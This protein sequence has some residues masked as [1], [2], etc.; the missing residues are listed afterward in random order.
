MLKTRGFGIQQII[1]LRLTDEGSIPETCSNA[2]INQ[3]QINDYDTDNNS[4]RKA[5]QGIG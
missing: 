5:I 1:T 4:K 2:R 3:K